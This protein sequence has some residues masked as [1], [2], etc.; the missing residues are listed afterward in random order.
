MLPALHAKTTKAANNPMVTVLDLVHILLFHP[1]LG[2]SL[3]ASPYA[4]LTPENTRSFV[5]TAF[6]RENIAVVVT[7]ID[8]G[9]LNKL[10]SHSFAPHSSNKA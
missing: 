6:S 2:V 4:P 3:F 5:H 8:S 1:G 7:G 10:A 9:L